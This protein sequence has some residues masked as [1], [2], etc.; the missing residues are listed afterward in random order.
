VAR[1]KVDGKTKKRILDFRVALVMNLVFNGGS[2]VLV[3]LAALANL[4]I[5][6]VVEGVAVDLIQVRM[7]EA[8]GHVVY[9]LAL[10]SVTLVHVVLAIPA[11]SL[12]TLV[13]ETLENALEVV[14]L[15]A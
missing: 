7:E 12:M 2:L 1:K 15:Q 9:L 10:I 11:S 6:K 5:R 13:V 3:A 4:L 8:V 14:L